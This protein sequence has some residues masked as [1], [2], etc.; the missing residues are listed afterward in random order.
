MEIPEVIAFIRKFDGFPSEVQII[1][2]QRKLERDLLR[3]DF[4][5]DPY[6]FYSAEYKDDSKPTNRH[7][8]IVFM[9][10]HHDF[11]IA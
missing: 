5:Y 10:P 4:N 8:E 7:N 3:S 6:V 9:K 1:R 2:N 11:A